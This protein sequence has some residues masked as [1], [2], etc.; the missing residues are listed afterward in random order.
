MNVGQLT[1]NHALCVRNSGLHYENELSTR[2]AKWLTNEHL[3]EKS[4]SYLTVCPGF[5]PYARC[6]ITRH[7]YIG[8]LIADG[9][10]RLELLRHSTASSRT[11]AASSSLE[12]GHWKQTPRERRM[13]IKHGDHR[14]GIMA[15]RI[16]T[17]DDASPDIASCRLWDS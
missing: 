12:W 9:S 2:S 1:N 13:A 17:Q 5:Y 16:V 3:Y 10:G 4:T 6:L 14:F 15:S 11:E 8:I 7:F